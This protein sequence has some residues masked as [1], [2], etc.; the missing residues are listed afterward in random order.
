[1][2]P[3]SD[4]TAFRTHYWK[5]DWFLKAIK[6]AVAE[7]VRTGGAFDFLAHPSCLVVEDP[8]FEAVKLICDL[9][10]DAGE[11]AAVV[12]LDAVAARGKDVPQPD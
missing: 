9:V 7:A 4:V 10:K 6:L 11:G 12:G 2:S 8:T 1:M 5:L 3:V